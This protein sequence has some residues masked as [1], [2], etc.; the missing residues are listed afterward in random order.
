MLPARPSCSGSIIQD[1][2]ITNPAVPTRDPQTG[3]GLGT[4]VSFSI[5]PGFTGRCLTLPA[6]YLLAT[7]KAFSFF[8]LFFLLTSQLGSY[9]V[10]VLC[11]QMHTE[12]H[13]NKPKKNPKQHQQYPISSV[14]F[15]A[16]LLQKGHSP[17]F[18]RPPPIP[19]HP[20]LSV[21][22]LVGHDER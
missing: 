18:P 10:C 14:I 8:S 12:A 9:S 13:A 20:S 19:S 15:F 4:L 1:T 16:L 6:G 22:L 3:D 5:P 11:M 21:D 2:A 7:L 17:L